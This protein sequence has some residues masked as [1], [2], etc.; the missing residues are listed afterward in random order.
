MSNIMTACKPTF[1]ACRAA[2]QISL[3]IEWIYKVRTCLLLS[4][5][6]PHTTDRAKV[7]RHQMVHTCLAIQAQLLSHRT[8]P[9]KC[10]DHGQMSDTDLHTEQCMPGS[11]IADYVQD[12]S[13]HRSPGQGLGLKPK[14]NHV[15][16]LQEASDKVQGSSW[17][18]ANVKHNAELRARTAW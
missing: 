2:N 13:D 4:T 6:V 9:Y 1:Q 10:C 5:Q 17:A 18:A 14:R 16:P 15:Q 11:G 8:E 3:E 7:C 12:I